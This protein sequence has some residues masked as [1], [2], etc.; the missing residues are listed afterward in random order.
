MAL[1]SSIMLLER[2]HNMERHSEGIIYNF[3]RFIV[4]TTVIFNEFVSFEIHNLIE[5]GK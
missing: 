2:C 5:D 4:E 1:E 3:D